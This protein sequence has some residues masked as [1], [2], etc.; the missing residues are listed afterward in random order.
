M[1]KQEISVFLKRNDWQFLALLITSS[2][3]FS[4]L[5]RL[6]SARVDKG[7]PPGMRDL[8]TYLFAGKAILEGDN[9]YLNPQVRIGPLGGLLIGVLDVFFSSGAIAW[10][11]LLSVPLGLAFFVKAC[12][13]EEGNKSFIAP[14]L[15]IIPWLSS[16]RENLVNIQITGFL[17][18]LY[19]SGTILLARKRD[20]RFFFLCGC[21]LIAFSVETKPHLLLFF[22]VVQALRFRQFTRILTVF[23]IIIIGHFSLTLFTAHN[24][25][26]EWFKILSGLQKDSTKAELPESI[27]FW[28]ILHQMG[29]TGIAT[30]Y[31]SLTIMIT[32]SIALLSLALKNPGLDTRVLSLLMPSLGFFFHYYDLAP[33]ISLF[34]VS[35]Y[36]KGKSNSAALFLGV[37]VIPE[38]FSDRKSIILLIVA[39]TYAQITT[40]LFSNFKFMKGMSRSLL[41]W[42]LY[43]LVI[44]ILSRSFD[45]HSLAVSATIF[46]IFSA[47]IHE[48]LKKTRT[49]EGNNKR[50]SIP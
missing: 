40:R 1:E 7:M 5:Y 24:L 47:S 11:A 39:L 41:T 20:S 45:I 31:I 50:T 44:T 19:A 37:F 36:A 49:Q 9:P 15:V 42:L 34:I 16:T 33:A 12:L 48:L 30:S 4:Y 28:P 29:I 17:L 46:F 14:W 26:F 43:A 13:L 21:I 32:V 8:G 18:I 27:A 2:L 10:I 35:T 22:F 6:G 3:I 38:N 25:T 23:S